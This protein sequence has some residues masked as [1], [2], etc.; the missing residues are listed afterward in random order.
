MTE[1]G[2]TGVGVITMQSTG[3]PSSDSV[4]GMNP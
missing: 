3:S 2:V 4:W 1:P